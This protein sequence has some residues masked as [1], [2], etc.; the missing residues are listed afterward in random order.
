[1]HAMGLHYL[2]LI[3]AI[4]GDHTEAISLYDQCLREA[5]FVGYR[6]GAARAH[7]HLA[8]SYKFNDASDALDHLKDC[9]RIRREFDDQRGL[10]EG[11]VVAAAVFEVALPELACKMLGVLELLPVD[12]ISLLTV[13]LDELRLKAGSGYDDRDGWVEQGRRLSLHDAIDLVL[14]ARM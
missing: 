2:G 12:A 6:R 10:V 3:A 8:D 5:E 9:L 1:M 4:K 11:L 7:L 13:K 14:S